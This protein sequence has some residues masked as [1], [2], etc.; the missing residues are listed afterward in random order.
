[1]SSR[2]TLN[3]TEGT[4]NPAKRYL[5]WKSNDKCFAYYDKGKG[6]D[7][8]VELPFK[9]QFLEHFHTVKGWHDASGSRIYANEVKFISK[10][11]LKVS[12]FKGG[13]LAEGLYSEIRSNIR[14]IGGVY[15]RSVYAV[16]SEGEI[17]NL[18]LKGA[19]VSAYTDFMSEHE[20]KIESA[21]VVINS[22]EDKKKGATKYSVPIFE[23]GDAFTRAENALADNKYTEIVEYFDKKNG[24]SDVSEDQHVPSGDPEDDVPF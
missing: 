16:D 13:Q 22:V 4:A 10:E 2:R 3:K 8:Q 20:N 9:F 12:S 5:E 1:M 11:E 21:W 23:I 14:D 18:Q 6:S 19:V 24:N 17:I 7:V 15:H